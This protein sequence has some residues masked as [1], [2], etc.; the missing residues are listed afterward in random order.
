MKKYQTKKKKKDPNMAE[1]KGRLSRLKDLYVDGLIDKDEYLRDRA[2][3]TE[4]LD[5]VDAKSDQQKKRI[6]KVREIFLGVL[7]EEYR[8]LGRAEKRDFWR[9]IL[10]RIEIIDGDIRF[11]F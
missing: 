9:A 4:L 1:I 2:K 7:E 11:Y 8:A 10:T 6:E 5:C 3:L